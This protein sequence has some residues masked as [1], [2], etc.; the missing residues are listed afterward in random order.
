MGLRSYSRSMSDLSCR[1]TL[2]WTQVLDGARGMAVWNT[3]DRE[4]SS[5]EPLGVNVGKKYACG[6]VRQLTDGSV[7]RTWVTMILIDGQGTMRTSSPVQNA[8]SKPGNMTDVTTWLVKNAIMSGV[9]VVLAHMMCLE[10]ILEE[11]SFSAQQLNLAHQ[12]LASQYLSWSY[13]SYLHQ[14]SCW[15]V[16]FSLGSAIRSLSFASLIAIS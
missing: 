13:L 12:I 15:L 8:K 2:I 4:A 14:L 7:V 5:I 6:V 16:R 10:A 3:L 1:L 9:G 11:L